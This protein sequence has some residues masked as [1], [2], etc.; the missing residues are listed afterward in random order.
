MLNNLSIGLRITI[1]FALVL[2][3]A[4]GVMTPVSINS[5]KNTISTA[6]NRELQSLFKNVK[7]SIK[8]ES[9]LAESLSA[10]VANI[11]EVQQAM[12][13]ND[14]ET[15]A[16]MLVPP[17]KVL[18]KKYGARQFQFH[19]PPAMSFLRVHK[20]EKFGDDL[21]SFRKTVVQ[22][23]N[24]K[25]TIGGI[26]KGVAGI[27]V[28]GV[29]PMNFQGK[30]TGSVEF[31]MSFGQPFFENFKKL[32]NIDLGLYVSNGDGFKKF[33]STME[34]SRF[35]P[36]QLSSIFKGN[37]LSFQ[38]THN[39]KPVTVF[40]GIITDYSNNPI[41]IL[42]LV[43]D[44]SQYANALSTATFLNLTVGAICIVL[45]LALAWLV[46]RAIVRPVTNIVDAMRDIAEG[47]GDLTLRLPAEGKNE[48]ATLAKAFNHFAE[49]V[50][51]LVVDVSSATRQLSNSTDE[52][53]IITDESNQ[54]ISRQRSEIDQVATAMNEMTA[55]VQEVARSASTAASSARQ[56]DDEATKGKQVVND[57]IQA[58]NSLASEVEL[59]A[60]VINKLENDSESIGSV[61][62]VIRGIAEQTNLLALNAAIE[63]ARA[64]EQ[65]RGFAV[66]ADEVRTLAS[67]TQSSTQEIHGMIERLQNGARQAVSVMQEGRVRASD[68]V[69]QAQK[70][71]ESL[72]EITSAI[73]AITDM[74]TH[75]ASA[76]EEQSCVAEEINSN[77]VNINDV[78]DKVT[79]GAHQTAESG[80]E[81]AKLANDL[82]SMVERFKT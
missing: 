75:I 77:V 70:A 9:R 36:E 29:V 15:L 72:N 74:N 16:K 45:G 32:Y 35:T 51:G 58:I 57:S 73:T 28:R 5:L 30:H 23:N 3:I 43:M 13:K 76:A 69:S 52:M 46:A 56:V 10:L 40:G 34:Q 8:S 39:D 62:D 64:G 48:I 81:L 11:P 59:A 66:V 50:R 53:S 14:R 25:Q 12:A 6:E 19:K 2:V 7:A 71:G 26:E 68:S 49:K 41:G 67:R 60:E 47:E 18:K 54:S 61:L 82:Q 42:E 17:F 55:T 65:G 24:T 27:G 44:R 79:M 37:E 20:P 38:S 22:T 31:G 80:T 33:A 1:T 4:V 63:A 78:A 21:S